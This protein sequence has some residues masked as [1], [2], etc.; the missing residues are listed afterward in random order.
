MMGD[1]AGKILTA[2]LTDDSRAVKGMKSRVC[3]DR[4]IPDVVQS[5]SRHKQIPFRT[6]GVSHARGQ[7]RHRL[8]MAGSTPGWAH[9]V[10][11]P[12]Q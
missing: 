1:Q 7:P 4:R 11:G 5:R 12:L 3:D 10:F 8:D 9:E 6:E 2:R